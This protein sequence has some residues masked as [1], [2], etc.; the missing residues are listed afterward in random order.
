M[1]NNGYKKTEEDRPENWSSLLAVYLDA[2]RATSFEWGSQD[3]CLFA[4]DWVKECLGIDPA[5]QWRGQYN[6]EA[7]ALKILKLGNGIRGLA[8]AT[9]TRCKVGFA[10]R[11][12]LVAFQD[13]SLKG[14][15]WATT[16]LGIL[17]G[18]YGLFAGPEGVQAVPRNELMKTAWRVGNL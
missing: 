16:S 7:G 17:D 1:T 15:A 11:G 4:A 13:P 8:N 2:R 3:C 14:P 5:E 10:H 18:R 9:F 6:T 12:D